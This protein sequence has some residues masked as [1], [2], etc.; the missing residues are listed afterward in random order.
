MPAQPT[1]EDR[2]ARHRRYLMC[3]PEFFEVSYSINPWMEPSRPSSAELAT[4]QW[5]VL[6]R[7]VVELGH[8]VELIE[9][10]PGLPDMVYAANGATVIDSKVL[11][12]RFRHPERRAEELPYFNWFSSRGMAAQAPEEINEGEGDLLL[13]GEHILAGC[14]FRTSIEAHAEAQEYF[15]R[16]VI[17]LELVDP[18][19]YHLDT[20]LAVLGD[21]EIMYYPAAFTPGSLRVLQ[22]LFPNAVLADDTDADVFGL[23]AISDGRHVLLSHEATGLAKQLRDRGYEPIGIDLSE[24]RKGGGGVKCCILEMRA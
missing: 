10:V 15:G 24:L 4:A 9:P 2:I 12:V 18:R 11:G 14:G 3:R 16:P 20:A 13:A 8:D 23:N 6:Y 1:P 5:E 19:F 22:R 7:R 17:G 21:G